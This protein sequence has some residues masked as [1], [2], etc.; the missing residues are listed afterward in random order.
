LTTQASTSP[1]PPSLIAPQI[2][3]NED[4]SEYVRHLHSVIESLQ[5]ALKEK[6]TRCQVLEGMLS[7]QREREQGLHHSLEH[8]QLSMD[9]LWRELKDFDIG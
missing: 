4:Q 3:S 2:V 9:G 5:Q 1:S 8:L 7:T 6:E